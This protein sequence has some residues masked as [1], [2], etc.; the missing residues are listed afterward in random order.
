MTH[1]VPGLP[2][3]ADAYRGP[4]AGPYLGPD[5]APGP[6]AG[7]PLHVQVHRAPPGLP[8]PGR[9]ARSW[10]AHILR[11]RDDL[12]PWTFFAPARPGQPLAELR[13]RLAV[14]YADTAG[15]ARG[16]PTG[17]DASEPGPDDAVERHGGYEVRY[18]RAPDLARRLAPADPGGFLRAAWATFLATPPPDPLR[19]WLVPYGGMLAVPARRI[20]ARPPGFWRGCLATIDDPAHRDPSSP[21]SAAALELLGLFLFGDAG[22]HPGQAGGVFAADPAATGGGV[23]VRPGVRRDL[24][25]A[26]AVKRCPHRTAPACGCPEVPGACALG[27]GRSGSVTWADCLACR[28]ADSALI[29]GHLA[30]FTGYGQHTAA[31]GRELE[32]LGCP[33]AFES[34]DAGFDPAAGLLPADPFVAARLAA[35]PPRFPALLLQSS[36]PHT[37]AAD[38]ARTVNF[39]MWESTRVSPAAVAACNALRAVIVPCA[40]NAEWFRASGVA[41][42]IRVV[43]L[44]LDPSVFHPGGLPGEPPAR[45]PGV[46]RFGCAGRTAHGGERKGLDAVVAAFVAALGDEPTAFLDVKIWADCAV[47]D[48][49]HP[50]VRLIRTAYTAAE[51]AGWYRSLDVFASASKGEGWGL[52]PLQAMACGAPA[53]APFWGGHAEYMTAHNAYPVAF[54]ELPAVGPIYGGLGDWCVVRPDSL[55]GQLRRA[56]EDEAGRRAKGL[57]AARDAATFTWGRTAEGVLAVLRE[58]AADGDPRGESPGAPRA[59]ADVGDGVWVGGSRACDEA[60][61]KYAQV[62]HVWKPQNRL[63]GVAC[64]HVADRR[65]GGLA[66]EWSEEQGL[67]DLGVPLAE[68]AAY[69]RRPGPLLV[70]CVAGSCRSTALATL[71]KVARGRD[72]FDAARDVIEGVYRDRGFMPGWRRETMEEIFAWAL[73]PPNY[74][75]AG[76]GMPPAA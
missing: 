59:A 18:G 47:V 38:P 33:V 24:A 48:P 41:V 15:L 55:R 20:A 31:L 50:R 63:E 56:F 21:G 62:V 26:Q 76:G 5:P 3:H 19:D 40:A 4:H 72:P 1:A 49:G 28:G 73:A 14:A 25:L 22:R 74:A 75:A 30:G 35:D 42:P 64:R 8:G 37:P 13:G 60:R 9:M 53:L 46:V 36:C 70:H 27:K 12:A 69:C 23:A 68:L 45:A 66:V 57:A 29:R 54:D 32:R 51:L 16:N 17:P 2:P 7:T 10:L 34:L 11:H 39:T 61:G 43:P 58:F 65:A 52:Q 67:G 6:H 71:A 44:G